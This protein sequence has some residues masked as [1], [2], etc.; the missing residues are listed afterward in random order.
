MNKGKIALITA[1]ILVG[2][3]TIGAIGTG[4]VAV[5]QFVAD[6]QDVKNNNKQSIAK[7]IYSTEDEVLNL[8]ISS[9]G[10]GKA[11][12]EINQSKDNLVKIKTYNFPMEK[13]E[14]NPSY[15]TDSKTLKI[16]SEIIES[17][18][19]PQGDG[20]VF[21]RMYNGLLYSLSG[22]YT[23]SKIIIE[24]PKGVNINLKSDESI[25]LNVEK[26]SVLSD[27]INF[28]SYYGYCSLPKFNNL[29]Q[30]KIRANGNITMD[31][32]EFI[33]ADSVEI[34]GSH[35]DISSN[36]LFSDYEKVGTLPKNIDLKANSVSIESYI[37]IAQDIKINAN[38][39]FSIAMDLNEYNVSG[40]IQLGDYNIDEIE[41]LENIDKSKL[42]I[43]NNIIE[44]E[45]SNGERGNIKLNV[46]SNGNGEFKNEQKESLESKLMLNR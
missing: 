42:N 8:D 21:E 2:I 10:N 33:N 26:A 25:S 45:F 30:I 35:V 11:S 17:M 22:D 38:N 44:G 27:S 15:D 31:V 40:K 5:P 43:K 41:V 14:V 24:V 9:S 13:L 46:F 23:G 32:R 37:P 36:G 20:N 29:K 1:A 18:A 6:V 16:N 34:L 3:G 28:D 39:Y 4:V 7:E 12:V 19:I